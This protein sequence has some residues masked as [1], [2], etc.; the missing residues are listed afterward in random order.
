MK[1]GKQTLESMSFEVFTCFNIFNFCLQMF[2]KLQVS[3]HRANQISRSTISIAEKNCEIFALVTTVK[4]CVKRCY[5]Y[6]M[7]RL[8]YTIFVFYFIAIIRIS[9][10]LLLLLLCVFHFRG[11]PCRCFIASS[12]Q[13]FE[14]R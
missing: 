13:K 14:T 6:T 8:F 5:I 10:L 11:F 12:I 7:F 4:L 1:K 3:N 9:L 2:E